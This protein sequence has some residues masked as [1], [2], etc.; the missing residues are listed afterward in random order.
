MTF[1]PE[2][3]VRTL[4]VP[5]GR[6]KTRGTVRL[7]EK[8]WEKNVGDALKSSLGL[9]NYHVADRFYAGVADRYIIGG[10]WMEMKVIPYA[11]NRSIDALRFV[12]P[13]QKAF[14]DRMIR[15]GDRTFVAILFVTPDLH[16]NMAIMPWPRFKIFESWTP[17]MICALPIYNNCHANLEDA[18]RQWFGRDKGERFSE[19]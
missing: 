1:N 5:K 4:R 8:T 6:R 11:G 19:Y 12:E 14:L 13:Q 2:D 7:L 17:K 18:L 3:P 9:F 16:S 15:A 10:N